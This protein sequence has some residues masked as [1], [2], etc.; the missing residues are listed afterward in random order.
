[1]PE[2]DS[3]R[4]PQSIGMITTSPQEN[5]WNWRG[6]QGRADI[7]ADQPDTPAADSLE[8][9]IMQHFQTLTLERLAYREII[10][11]IVAEGYDRVVVLQVVKQ[12]ANQRKLPADITSP[13]I[14]LGISAIMFFWGL[15]TPPADTSTQVKAFKL[16]VT[17]I[18]GMVF[19][20]S[21]YTLVYKF[22]DRIPR[23]N[24]LLEPI[25]AK[26]RASQSDVKTLDAQFL[27]SQIKESDYE[28][29]L[30][31]LMGKQRGKKYFRLMRNQKHFG[32]E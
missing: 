8:G 11:K 5:Y 29:Q 6:R 14:F 32:L 3:E 7:P 31:A 27:S 26:N 30:I 2:N 28:S 22:Y 23:L 9:Q 20:P 21:V 15:S 10:D 19:L 16:L 4:R 17:A 18:G 12:W 1:M 13:L 25:L 24:A